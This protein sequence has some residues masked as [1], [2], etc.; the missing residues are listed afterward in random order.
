MPTLD[1][2]GH[3]ERSKHIAAGRAD[4]FLKSYSPDYFLAE[5][6]NV[7]SPIGFLALVDITRE[8]I[9]EYVTREGDPWMSEARNFSP[10]WYLIKFDNNGLVWGIDYGGSSTF[11]EEAAREDFAEADRAYGEWLD[12]VE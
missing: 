9:A 8:D 4:D 2:P 1:N 5:T 6:G 11:S 10:G 3:F 12:I 7:E